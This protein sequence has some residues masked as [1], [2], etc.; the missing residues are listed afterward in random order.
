MNM[1]IRDSLKRFLRLSHIDPEKGVQPILQDTDVQGFV[2]EVKAE[3]E[4]T[5][6]AWLPR[7]F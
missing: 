3:F 5:G 7:L 2:G 6:G 1:K 4:H